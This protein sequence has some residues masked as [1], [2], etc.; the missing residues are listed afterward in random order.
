MKGI[1]SKVLYVALTAVV[2]TALASTAYAAQVTK[3]ELKCAGSLGKAMTKVSKTVFK[4]VAKCRDADISGKSVG[5]CPDAKTAGKIAKAIAKAASS[6]EKG[7]GSTCSVSG[8]ACVADNTCP[9]LGNTK[10]LCKGGGKVFDQA[11]L[12]FPGP[13]CEATL[14]HAIDTGTDMGQCVGDVTSGVSDAMVDLVYGSIDNGAGLDKGTGKCLGTI[15]KGAAK[16]MGTIAKG[17]VKCRANILDEKLVGV[18]SDCTS[19]DTKLVDKTAKA[20]SKLESGIAKKCTD[21]QIL[22]L[23]L[24]GSGVGATLN[25]ADAQACITA[26]VKELTDSAELP[27]NRSYSTR[28]FVEAAYPPAASCGDNVVNQVRH[29]FLQIGEECDGSDDSACPGEC[30]PPGDVFSCTCGDIARSRTFTNGFT[31]DLDSGWNGSSHNG[32]TSDGAGYMTR[33]INCDCDALTACSCTG[34]SVDSL[35]DIQGYQKPVCSYDP[36]GAENC[37]QKNTVNQNNINED[38][39]CRVCDA[40]TS[41]SG[42][43]C[44]DDGDCGSQC[45]DGLGAPTGPCDRQSDCGVGDT[46]RG[47]C[48]VTA[49]CIKIHNGDPLPISRGGSTPVCVRSEFRADASGT[50]DLSDGSSESFISLYSQVHIAG[51]GFGQGTQKPCPTCGGFCDS[52]ARQ[53][54]P[55]EGSCSLTTAT[56]CR[57]DTDCPGGESCTT[58]STDCGAGVTCNL[59][60]VCSGGP[61][62]GL[63]CRPS[64]A[65]TF[66]GIT[67]NDCPPD[68][69]NNASGAG[70]EINFS[71]AT[72]G[73]VAM[74]AS[75]PCEAPGFENYDCPCPGDGGV[76]PEPNSCNYG[77][78]AGAELGTG[79]STGNGGKGEATVCIGGSAP[80][81]TACD[82]DGDCPGGT[83]SDNPTHCVG[84]VATDLQP[85]VDNSTCGSGSCVDACPTGRCVPLCSPADTVVGG[86]NLAVEGECAAGPLTFLCD[87]KTFLPCAAG[88]SGTQTGCEAGINGVLG[89]ADDIPGAGTCIEEPKA[90][91][92]Y[93]VAATGTPDGT[94]PS[95]VAAYCI[96]STSS[97]AVNGSA[98]LGGP[99]RLRTDQ[100]IQ[101]NTLTIP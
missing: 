58:A 3:A 98:G 80:P 2:A 45:Y 48:D 30:M 56:S 19:I 49:Y 99:G 81:L 50:S 26:S 78:N 34:N 61:N 36:N 54:L 18:P 13:F 12:N 91:F 68:T 15:G 7:C 69:A 77:C 4:G 28:S 44:Q 25:V 55:C 5:A 11:S 96:G 86:R 33:R 73:S 32:G 14:G 35:C 27:S 6:G 31:A 85:C 72:T 62:N 66:F 9:P 39:D 100:V 17:I 76:P 89:D 75:L 43:F 71:P 65:T 8:F 47:Q 64:A 95:T 74:A 94:T 59:G 70:L 46:C 57:F 92:Q 16:L 51:G 1:F 84:D 93:P 38:D 42:T 37:D 41:N 60:L 53:Y 40:Y 67:S 101:C 97:S 10:E 21:A 22:S 24:C 29:N 87:G 63:A 83:C 79:C 90:C 88:D 82:D 23:D 20:V 52:G